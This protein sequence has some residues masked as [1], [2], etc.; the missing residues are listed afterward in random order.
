MASAEI[1]NRLHPFIIASNMLTVYSESDLYRKI[2][3][4]NW[5]K[6]SEKEKYHEIRT[7]VRNLNIDTCFAALGASNE[8]QLGGYFPQDKDDLLHTLDRMI[9]ETREEDLSLY[10]KNLKHL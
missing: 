7:L 8:F 3:C 1:F 2:R 9:S 4:G 6:E 5:E 10:R